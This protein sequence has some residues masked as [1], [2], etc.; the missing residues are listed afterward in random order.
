MPRN[1]INNEISIDHFKPNWRKNRH[2]LAQYTFHILQ[3]TQGQQNESK[4]I[5][6]KFVQ[7]KYSTTSVQVAET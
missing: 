7:R 4:V 6:P 1:T 5:N 2:C 3:V